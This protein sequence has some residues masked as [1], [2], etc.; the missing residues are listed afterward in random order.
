[1]SAGALSVQVVSDE[2]DLQSTVSAA[3]NEMQWMMQQWTSV[4]GEQVILEPQGFQMG[5]D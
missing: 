5:D 4:S 1:M 2:Q 3:H